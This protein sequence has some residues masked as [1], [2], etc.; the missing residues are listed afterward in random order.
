[1]SPEQSTRLK[2]GTRVCF[3]G[4]GADRGRVSAIEANYVTIKWEDGHRSYSGHR[5]MKRVEVLTVKR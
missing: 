3:N 4:D 2:V 5:E 1:M